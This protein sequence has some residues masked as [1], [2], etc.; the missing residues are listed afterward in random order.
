MILPLILGGAMAAGRGG[1]IPPD[2]VSPRLRLV[3]AVTDEML[4]DMQAS[5]DGSRLLTTSLRNFDRSYAPRL[6]DARRRIVLAVLGGHPDA[7][8][9]IGFSPDGKYAFTLSYKLLQKWDPLRGTL[10]AK[11]VAVPGGGMSEATFAPDG[12]LRF[13]LGGN[14]IGGMRADGTDLPNVL[15]SSPAVSLALSPD[16]LRLAVGTAVRRAAPGPGPGDDAGDVV[17]SVALMNADGSGK[18]AVKGDAA[19]DPRKLGPG[20]TEL[21]FS[22]DGRELLATNYE[23]G[24]AA[25]IDALS[26]AIRFR[27][28][29]FIAERGVGTVQ[30]G[31]DFVGK[32]GER[33]LFWDAKGL[34][35]LIDRKTLKPVATLKGHTDGV[36]EL[37]I[38]ADRRHAATYGDD[39]KL[40]LWN[41]D[42][43]TG[44]ALDTPDDTP[45]AAAFSAAGERFFLGFKSGNLVSYDS[46]SGEARD[47]SFVSWRKSHSL[48][49]LSNGRIAVLREEGRNL[50]GAILA[51][52]VRSLDAL[53]TRWPIEAGLDPELSADGRFALLAAR[54]YGNARLTNLADPARYEAKRVVF[55]A[56]PADV[57]FARRR[58][59][60]LTTHDEGE[61]NLIDLDTGDLIQGWKFDQKND[62]G[63]TRL[64]PDGD[65]AVSSGRKETKDEPRII[66]WNV[67]EGVKL[68]D[69]GPN[70]EY[71]CGLSWSPDGNSVYIHNRADF[72]RV[73]AATG[74]TVVSFARPL[75]ADGERFFEDNEPLLSGDG[76]TVALRAWQGFAA[77]DTATGAPLAIR[78]S[79]EKESFSAFAP[80]GRLASFA[81]ERDAEVLDVRTGATVG[82][83]VTTDKIAQMVFTAD[84]KRLLTLD[85]VD[86]IVVWDVTGAGDPKR[87]GSLQ[88][89]KAG[90]WLVLDEEG[91]YDAADP[92]DVPAARY[93]FAWSGGLEPVTVPQLKSRF[94]DPGLFAKLLGINL[95]PRRAVPALDAVKLYPSVDVKLDPAKATRA[96]VEVKERDGGG[97][98]RIVVAVNGK[99]VDTREGGGFFRLDL[100]KFRPFLIPEGLLGKEKNVLTVTAANG[101]ND[102]TSP[103]SVL[104]LALPADLKVPDARVH[105]LFVGAGDYVGSGGDLVAPAAD[106]R[107]LATAFRRAA[108]RLLPG[109]VEV[110]TLTTATGDPRPSREAIRTWMTATAAK[111][112]ARDTVVVFMAGHGTSSIGEEKDYFFLTPDADP[113]DVGPAAMGVAAVS[114]KELQTWL[115]AIPAAKQ[116]LVLDTCHSGAAAKSLELSSRSLSG[117]Y[118]RAYE[119]IR[120]GSGTWLLAG[121][122]ADQLSY[123]SSSVEHGMLTYA[124]LE[125]IDLGPA[126]GA[127]R[128]GENGDG[129]LDVER[130]LRYAAERVESLKQ[131]A[132]VAGVQRPEFRRSKEGRSFDLGV[133]K[134]EDKGALKLKSPKPILI[135]G[136]FSQD[137][138]DPAGLEKSVEAEL[139]KG[140][141]FKPWFDVAKHPGA[142]RVAGTY[143]V[144][145]A[146]VR[147]KAV[148][149]RFDSSG[150]RTTL[151]TFSLEGP[152][153][154]LAEKLR[155]ELER[156]LASAKS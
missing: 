131:E 133:V 30:M 49:L 60:V 120:D 143:T 124:L 73:D 137:E 96:L 97:I 44:I 65:V 38:S 136:A 40:Y 23:A 45:T 15:L 68:H 85:G 111:A 3:P 123:E 156:R 70:P 27:A 25:L 113:G 10:L 76:K 135:V 126:S 92:S 91:R 24:T 26:G 22:P 63:V 83:L 105:A 1:A 110:V 116:V 117:E 59:R 86:G 146:I 104:S 89:G 141:G 144:E 150:S 46:L 42:R 84:G 93:V 115:A 53:S 32:D 142:Y 106:A 88:L 28:P 41:I 17:S 72:R 103:P 127:L 13:L 112:G 77:W 20:S 138:E 54:D 37:R 33:M 129:F 67:D 31:A 64:S 69:L 61:A 51:G 81:T 56:V 35:K 55:K 99:T 19:G 9:Q 152:P 82:R 18:T 145:G 98:G 4:I 122:A 128:A 78:R 75:G 134:A 71:A 79:A 114:G 87:L 153:E 95:E 62:L 101:T 12:S 121:S 2:S 43:A 6:W 66:L 155:E 108:E 48:R 8:R 132:N 109:R 14:R 119:A 29:H 151:A 139:R 7:V 16:G 130:W 34:G 21:H 5:A 50:R 52:D 125:A 148:L 118:G 107:E 147:L 154:V 58:A 80:D 39:T 47:E 94:Y 57:S 102:L 11:R 90:D 74:K 140:Q 149:Q 100:D 36:R